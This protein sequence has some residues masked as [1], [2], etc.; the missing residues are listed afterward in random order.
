MLHGDVQFVIK[1]VDVM[2]LIKNF[3]EHE[4]IDNEG[5]PLYKM[6]TYNEAPYISINIKLDKK[7]KFA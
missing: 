4:I 2:N 5:V 1:D 6:N 3:I 7:I